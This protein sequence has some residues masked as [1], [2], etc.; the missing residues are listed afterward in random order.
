MKVH[1]YVKVIIKYSME[2][3]TSAPFSIWPN[4]VKNSFYFFYFFIFFNFVQTE[5]L[6]DHV[7]IFRGDF[8]FSFSMQQHTTRCR[9]SG[10]P[11][12]CRGAV[13]WRKTI[14]RADIRRSRLSFSIS[15]RSSRYTA[16]VLPP[17]RSLFL[18][19]SLSFSSSFCGVR[20]T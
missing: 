10:R 16:C 14:R 1:I 11:I 19:F 7:G 2:I 5:H 3:F 4:R 9:R 20:Y 12:L 17:S 8:F 6:R 15:R 18:S 13:P